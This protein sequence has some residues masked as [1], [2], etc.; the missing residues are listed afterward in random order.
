MKIFKNMVWKAIQ[1]LQREQTGGQ[2]ST[3]G[4]AS[5]P[6]SEQMN[7][8]PDAAF[9]PYQAS[10]ISEL[11]DQMYALREHLGIYFER[12]MPMMVAKKTGVPMFDQMLSG[13]SGAAM[14]MGKTQAKKA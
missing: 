7:S 8:K 1:E 2:D 10:R 5:A 12:P 6:M 3:N 14:Q 9:T 11:E 13:G 4:N